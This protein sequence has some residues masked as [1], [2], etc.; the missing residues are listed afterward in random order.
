MIF[1]ANS[2]GGKL[3]DTKIQEIQQFLTDEKETL[4]NLALEVANA[5]TDYE[6]AKAKSNYATQLARVSG[7]ADTF[8]MIKKG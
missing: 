5:T 3:V 7:I 8:E 4:T 1:K 2:R 6:H